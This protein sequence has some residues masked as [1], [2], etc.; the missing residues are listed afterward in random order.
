[1]S[2]E[3]ALPESWSDESNIAWRSPIRGVGISSPIVWGDRVF[4]TSQIGRGVRRPGNHPTL[5]Q[6]GNAASSGERGITG[7]QDT[8]SKVVFVVTA[9]SRLDG[10]RLWEYQ[11][12]AEGDLGEVHDKNNLASSS[13]VTDGQR[14]YAWFGTGQLVALDMNG[15]PLWSRHLGREYA[16]FDIGWG[17]GSSP[18]LFNDTL[19]LPCYHSS[20][21]LLGVDTASGKTRWRVPRGKGVISYSTPLLIQTA[22]GPEVIV[23]SSEGISGHNPANGQLLWH[24]QESNSFPIPMPVSHDGLIYTS[25]GYRSGPYMAIRPGGRGDVTRTHVLWRVATGAPYVSSLVH[26]EGVLY[27]AGDVGVLSAIDAKTGERLWQERTGGVF[28]AS[29]VAGDGK[30]YLLS[31][32]GQTIVLA[33]GRNPRVLARN[34]LDARQLASPAISG[35]RLFIRTDD[36]VIAVG[37]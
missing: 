4:V 6:G 21:Y 17:H 31:E 23:N 1:V 22:A 26:Y 16:A 35:G 9:L 11:L 33:A 36:G 13:P 28:T 30:V 7:P 12:A 34:R 27:M 5:V 37:K 15:K 20:S 3:K 19:I 32:D 25:R 8:G 14:V 10:Q 24:V 2:S 29:P 18:L